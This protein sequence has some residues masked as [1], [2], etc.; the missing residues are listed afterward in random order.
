MLN[1]PE[2]SIRKN[3]PGKWRGY[4]GGVR[5][6]DFKDSATESAEVA[7]K[8]WLAAPSKPQK[9]EPAKAAP[10]FMEHV[11]INCDD[12]T[13][14][15]LE[16][17]PRFLKLYWN[18]QRDFGDRNYGRE[19]CLHEAAHAVLMEQDGIKNVRFAG[20]DIVY[21]PFRRDFDGS[22]ARAIGDDQPDAVVDDNYIFKI[23]QHMAAGGVALR[24]LANIQD[25]VG[26]RGDYED[27]ARKYANRPLSTGGASEHVWSRAQHAV[28]ARLAEP[29]TRATVLA[30]AD[31]YFPL[32]YPQG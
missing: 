23:V 3:R 27:F 25:D 29:E 13:R 15:H 6:I 8:R 28:A 32:L 21:N 31:Q 4:I 22:S 11:K 30:R 26:D 7:A 5:V 14:L 2:A 9:A 17:D 10:K 19:V 18:M 16:Q 24:L 12:V 1:K 20:P